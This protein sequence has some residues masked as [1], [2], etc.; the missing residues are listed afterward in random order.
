MRR[1]SIKKLI[2]CLL[3]VMVLFSL[4]P[5]VQASETE[6]SEVEKELAEMIF[7]GKAWDP[8]AFLKGRN[9][10]GIYLI[11][12]DERGFTVSG[13][14]GYGLFFYFYNPS[15]VNIVLDSARN[16]VQ[17]ADAWDEKMETATDYRKFGL[18]LVSASTDHT[19][20]KF[21]LM[22]SA[23][24]SSG[25]YLIQQN[26]I[27][28]QKK[29]AERIYEIS[30][31]ELQSKVQLKEY[32]YGGRVTFTGYE[33][34]RAP[35]GRNE[36]TKV[37]TYRGSAVL[38]LDVQQCYW[39]TQTSD[40]G[41]GYKNQINAA[42]FS[43]PNEI[44]NSYES[45][46]SVK[47][48]WD[49]Y[50]TT[51]MIVTDDLT[52]YNSLK[53]YV[54]ITVIPYEEDIGYKLFGG[55]KYVSGVHGANK[56]VGYEWSYNIWN[57]DYLLDIDN[58]IDTLGW[59]LFS[60]NEFAL[61]KECVSS[62]DL[63]AYYHTFENK[64]FSKEDLLLTNMVDEGRTLGRNEVTVTMDG[65]NGSPIFELKNYG[66]NHS[67]IEEWFAYNLFNGGYD[68]NYNET[69]PHFTSI[70]V[71]EKGALATNN[72]LD[73]KVS[74][75]E[76]A[77]LHFF[78]TPEMAAEFRTYVKNAMANDETVVLFRYAETDY[79]SKTLTALPKIDGHAMVSWQTMFLNFDV[80]QL[81][82]LDDEQSLIIKPVVNDPEDVIGSVQTPETSDDIDLV[83][84]KWKED[85]KGLVS[86]LSRLMGWLLIVFLV[87][88]VISFL[89]PT[90]QRLFG[91]KG[92]NT[93]YVNYHYHGNSRRGKKK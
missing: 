11:A 89:I 80:I 59:L 52:L 75:A 53:P 69:Y 42:Y 9:E 39:R 57:Y 33:E 3:T 34:G 49:E 44:W 61:G 77:D 26:A 76:I 70:E 25:G 65:K 62:D 40:L 15:G 19:Y 50:R 38:T 46:Y 36:D 82:F 48:E 18:K 43:V 35:G 23:S 47:C 63:L 29:K 68:V 45:L 91:K 21:Q 60:E 86:R 14:A 41:V 37:A 81:G 92:S 58:K 31:F 20:M 2:A 73:T 55:A 56:L 1:S 90:I 32:S 64:N 13:A 84:D 17:M 85:L 27:A 7:D 93:T 51:P 16:K 87:L 6:L 24:G 30:G 22:D 12:V 66:S 71:F 67:M 5:C 88:F 79:Y 54:G 28:M 72:V 78:N 4:A 8:Q 10:K 83:T 74:D